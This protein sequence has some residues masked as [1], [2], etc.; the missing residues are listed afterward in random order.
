MHERREAAVDS[1]LLFE[2]SRV[3]L[4]FHEEHI[5]ELINKATLNG[6]ED[7]D[8]EAGFHQS[9]TAARLQLL[10]IPLRLNH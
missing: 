3:G 1:K 10:R 9:A 4:V 8:G 6:S 5:D 2:L 7:G